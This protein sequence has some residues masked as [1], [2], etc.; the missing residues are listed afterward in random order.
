MVND[1]APNLETLGDAGVSYPGK[2]GAPGL[3]RAL[4]ALLADPAQMERY[5]AAAAERAGRVYSWEAVTDAYEQ[6]ATRLARGR[7]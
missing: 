6:L 3:R 4:E 7:S 5:R 2:E 1:H